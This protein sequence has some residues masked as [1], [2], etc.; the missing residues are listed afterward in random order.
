MNHRFGAWPDFQQEEIDAVVR[1]LQSGQVN[2]WTGKEGREFEREFA[3]FC[4][5]DYAVALSNGTVALELALR[6]L[7]IGLGDEVVVTPRTFL[8]SVSAIAMV[9]A[10]P[11]FA[12]VDFSS[13]NVC[14]PSY[15]SLIYKQCTRHPMFLCSTLYLLSGLSICL[16]H[17]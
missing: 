12:E 11:V 2:Y 15:S 4:G 8:A 1:V 7:G 16:S 9:G 14:V 17:L 5:T 3:E 6:S 13:Q 10:T